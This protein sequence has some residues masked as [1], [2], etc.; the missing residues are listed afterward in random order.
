MNKQ[1]EI[2]LANINLGLNYIQ[3]ITKKPTNNEVWEDFIKAFQQ[4]SITLLENDE[5]NFRNLMAIFFIL[6]GSSLKSKTK[7][8]YRLFDFSNNNSL[9]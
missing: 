4:E 8:I 5:F 7:G 6:S 3:L 2:S 9:N 1:N